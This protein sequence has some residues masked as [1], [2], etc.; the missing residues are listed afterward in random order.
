MVLYEPFLRFPSETEM[1]AISDAL[2][3]DPA[4]GDLFWDRTGPRVTL[5]ALAGTLTREGRLAVT[6]KGRQYQASHIAWFMHNGLW[7]TSSV[8]FR[9]RDV[10][11]LTPGNLFLY[12]DLLPPTD[13]ARSMRVY[14]ERRAEKERATGAVSQVPHVN[15][16]YD[17]KTWTVRASWDG[18]IVL[19]SFDNRATAESYGQQCLAGREYLQRHPVPYDYV[20]KDTEA[21][22]IY[23]GDTMLLSL[24]EA[25]RRFAYD[26]LL[27]ALY[28][29]KPERLQ[30]TPAAEPMG[31][32]RLV[33][34][35]RGR[36][37]TA[38]MLAW[39]LT[40]GDWPKRKQL[41]Y[42]DGNQKNI[43]LVN[44]YLKGTEP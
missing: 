34:R 2:T 32:K 6:V 24:G 16:G 8:R 27:G 18:R 3:Y 44:L 4:T 1:A 20:L 43:A 31:H 36:I 5:G 10:L 39:F 28:R 22:H 9:N 12:E 33:V 29:R 38:G 17:K 25:H 7:P 23:T 30:G 13:K 40:H 26:P 11:D 41:A 19:A 35:T 21:E 15:L 14:R 42:R 37:F